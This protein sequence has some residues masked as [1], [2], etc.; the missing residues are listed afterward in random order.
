MICHPSLLLSFWSGLVGIAPVWSGLVGSQKQRS[1]TKNI[2]CFGKVRF[3]S[4]DGG[5]IRILSQGALLGDRG[6]DARGGSRDGIRP[7][8]GNTP[9]DFWLDLAL[10]TL[11]YIDL[12]CSQTE[13]PSRAT[14]SWAT[15]LHP[16]HRVYQVYQSLVPLIFFEVSGCTKAVP[17]VYQAVPQG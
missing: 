17:R 8:Q 7:S 5:K 6:R 16:F 10:S 13:G 3:G 14:F 4:E 11:I 1:A 15:P 9:Q 12:A 2:L